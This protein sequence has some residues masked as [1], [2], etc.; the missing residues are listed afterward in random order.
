MSDLSAP[1]ELMVVDR[2]PRFLGMLREA[3]RYADSPTALRHEVDGHMA[4]ASAARKMPDV[5]LLSHELVD[6]TPQEWTTAFRRLFPESRA[7][8]FVVNLGSATTEP[9][10][11]AGETALLVVNN[12]AEALDCLEWVREQ[13]DRLGPGSLL[14]VHQALR[15]RD[16]RTPP[17]ELRTLRNLC[18][19]AV[20]RDQP[21]AS[22]IIRV[23]AYAECIAERLGMPQAAR[24]TL[25]LASMLHDIGHVAVPDSVLRKATPLSPA[26]ALMMQAHARAGQSILSAHEGLTFALAAEVARSHHEQWD[27]LGY[28]DGL[29]G[30][31]IPLSGRIVALADSFDLMT[32]GQSADDTQMDNALG[33][34]REHAGRIFDP[35]LVEEVAAVMPQMREIWRRHPTAGDQ[36]RE[37]ALNGMPD[38]L[39]WSGSGAP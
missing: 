12:T 34:L 38:P 36:P 30:D 20:L 39:G 16:Y 37:L 28:P 15:L 6:P 18:R 8:V 23:A 7:K 4:L 25:G 17:G 14:S 22:H 10:A 1:L 27:G 13:A 9:G 35:L 19:L 11:P 29:A 24:E 2:Y 32:S 31:A 33:F 26:E 3:A 21:S 5:V